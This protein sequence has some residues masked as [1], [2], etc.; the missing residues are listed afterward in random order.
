MSNRD[1]LDE[2]TKRIL[3]EADADDSKDSKPNKKDEKKTDIEW[4]TNEI[5]DADELW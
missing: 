3:T 2:E 5:E 1:S 4:E